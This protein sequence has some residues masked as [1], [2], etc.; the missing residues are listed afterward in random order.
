MA[1]N[2][3]LS[4]VDDGARQFLRHS[5]IRPNNYYKPQKKLGV[6]GYGFSLGELR[7]YALLILAYARKETNKPHQELPQE[8]PSD[9]LAQGTLDD[10]VSALAKMV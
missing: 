9:S 3:I 4:I 7:R 1:S 2:L 8:F 10:L 5:D 6:G